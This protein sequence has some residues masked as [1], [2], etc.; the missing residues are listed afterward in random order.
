MPQIEE[1]VRLPGGL[2][3][4]SLTALHRGVIGAAQ[5]GTDGALRVSVEEHED[6]TPP[7]VKTR[8]LEREYRAVV[9][10]KLELRGDDGRV[11]RPSCARSPSRASLADYRA[12]TRRT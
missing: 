2:R 9:E 11:S 4:V 12:A 1:H 7:P 10:E 6:V 8:E 5:T 3:A